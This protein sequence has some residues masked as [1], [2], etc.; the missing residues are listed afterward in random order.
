MNNCIISYAQ[1]GGIQKV[2]RQRWQEE[3]ERRRVECIL[4]V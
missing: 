2:E 4:R 1:L 3:E